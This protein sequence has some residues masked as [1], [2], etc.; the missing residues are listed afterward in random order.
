[1][2]IILVF[3][4]CILGHSN[5]NISSKFVHFYK[6]IAACGWWAHRKYFTDLDVASPA[7]PLCA[8]RAYG[9]APRFFKRHTT[10][11][12]MILGIRAHSVRFQLT[13]QIDKVSSDFY[14]FTKRWRFFLWDCVGWYLI[15][16]RGAFSPPFDQGESSFS[17][18][19]FDVLALFRRLSLQ[20]MIFP[21]N[22]RV[23]DTKWI[24][25]SKTDLNK[26]KNIH[27]KVED[28]VPSLVSCVFYNPSVHKRIADCEYL[29][30][31]GKYAFET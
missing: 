18:A 20:Y 13:V 8:L 31:C 23:D 29:H 6:A 22:V 26:V 21:C 7:H 10:W 12:I 4:I 16:P 2:D 24:K 17:Y 5:S 1:M 3:C 11:L 9:T 14:V 19:E 30:C 28:L 25:K 15:V 27:G